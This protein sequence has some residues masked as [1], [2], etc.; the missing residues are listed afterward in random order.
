M[1]ETY[2][3]FD[4][5]AG[6]NVTET[7]WR[8]MSRHWLP[9]GVL[10]D[11]LDK[12]QVYADS[13]GMQ[14]KVRSGKA[15][16]HGH[17]YSSD[18]EKTLPIP[19][20]DLTNPRIDWV[21]VRADFVANTVTTDTVQGVPAASPTTPP[22]TQSSAMWETPLATVTVPA[23]AT[24]IAAG[25]VTESRVFSAQFAAVD[26]GT[27]TTVPSALRRGLT[28]W[29]VS[30]ADAW[31]YNG[32]VYTI[33]YAP[34]RVVQYLVKADA[35]LAAPVVVVRTGYT[36]GGTDGWSAWGEIAATSR[37]A[38]AFVSTTETTTSTSPA[39][40]T[41]VGPT[42]T[43]EVGPSGRL[44]VAVSAQARTSGAADYAYAC[45]DVSGPTAVAAGIAKSVRAAGTLFFGG[46]FTQVLTG[47]TP[48]SYTVR[49]KY[50]VSAG[51]GTFANREI[52]AVPL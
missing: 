1:A 50:A 4:D 27:L 44:L 20:A 7:Q 14:V 18:A 26:P 34:E 30:T 48:G 8:E 2:Y 49:A 31:P 39:D 3:P 35:S 46:S 32:V 21:V 15:W 24:T 33:K 43:V 25:N 16:V 45:V 19:A 47:L 37:A 6:A 11:E 36:S 9:T 52:N 51:T 10:T 42:V 29:A 13:S 28:Y 17:Y 41:T 23:A 5:G 38:T 22:L 40:L 12:L